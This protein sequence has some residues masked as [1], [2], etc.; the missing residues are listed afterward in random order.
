MDGDLRSLLV[1][2]SCL[3]DEDAEQTV[4]ELYLELYTSKETHRGRVGE[5]LTHD[6][7]KVVFFED[8]FY[9]AFRTS[10]D[11]I[12][13][14]YG[15]LEFDRKRGERVRW[16][17]ELIEGKVY[18]SECWHHH[19]YRHG[20]GSSGNRPRAHRLY[21]YWPER[22]VVWLIPRKEKEWRFS[23]AHVA[24]RRHLREY[25]ENAVQIWTKKAPRD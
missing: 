5:L 22:Y 23:T 20:S 6:N 1:D 11:K 14:P 9:H 12:N 10:P 3:S 21:V 15:K 13:R 25:T 17:G 24:S 2:L 18:E 8:R 7:Q 16:I 4:L 19:P